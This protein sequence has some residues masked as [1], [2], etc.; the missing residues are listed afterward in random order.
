MHERSIF[1]FCDCFGPDG[2]SSFKLSTLGVRHPGRISSLLDCY[3]TRHSRSLMFSQLWTG[4]LWRWVCFSDYTMRS[5]ILYFC[6]CKLRWSRT[7]CVLLAC[8][9]ASPDTFSVMNCSVSALSAVFCSCLITWSAVNLCSLQCHIVEQRIRSVCR[10]V[11]MLCQQT[12]PKL[13]FANVNMA[14]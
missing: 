6:S 2:S 12:L 14:S 7:E 10:I 1:H 8:F 3:S 9:N 4:V 5:L 11:C 13:W